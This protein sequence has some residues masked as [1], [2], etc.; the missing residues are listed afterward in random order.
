MRARAPSRARQVANC[1]ED[2]KLGTALTYTRDEY[3]RKGL[4]RGGLTSRLAM[5]LADLYSPGEADVP[6]CDQ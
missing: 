4:D 6:H 5:S 1:T 2:R 3:D